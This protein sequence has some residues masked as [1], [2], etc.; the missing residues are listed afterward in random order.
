MKN[1]KRLK[2]DQPVCLPVVTQ[3]CCLLA[4]L[5]LHEWVFLYVKETE[6]P[7][8]PPSDPEPAGQTDRST[9][10]INTAQLQ[11]WLIC[12]CINRGK[13]NNSI[14]YRDILHTKEHMHIAWKKCSQYSLWLSWAHMGQSQ[15]PAVFK[16][17]LLRRTC[18]EM[19]MQLLLFLPPPPGFLEH[20]WHLGNGNST[21][22]Q[23]Y[24]LFASFQLHSV[25]SLHTSPSMRI[26]SPL[27]RLPSA[28]IYSIFLSPHHLCCFHFALSF[29]AT[30]FLFSSSELAQ[31]DHFCAFFL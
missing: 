23:C 3:A 28:H 27:P 8:P 17:S 11:K 30:R 1:E 6:F 20:V 12:I 19:L 21:F 13:N 22:F 16:K 5:C 26:A 2:N 9:H 31:D 15:S 4:D 7:L 25:V 10:M 24:F 29:F 18:Y 14:T